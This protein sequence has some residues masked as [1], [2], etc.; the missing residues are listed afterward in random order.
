M[1]RLKL[2]L[3]CLLTAVTCTVFAQGGTVRGTV[4][5]ASTGEP[6]AFASIQVKGTMTGAVTDLDGKYSIT[7]SYTHLDVYKRQVLLIIMAM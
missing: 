3:V 5:D 7:V 6:V 4:T 1:K 2:L